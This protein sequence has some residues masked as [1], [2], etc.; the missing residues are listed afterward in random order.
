MKR[1]FFASLIFIEPFCG[2]G[3]VAQGVPLASQAPSFYSGPAS[4]TID[5][6][7]TIEEIFEYEKTSAACKKY[8]SYLDDSDEPK[9]EIPP[10]DVHREEIYCGKWL[11]LA[12]ETTG[13]LPLPVLLFDAIKRTWPE[14]V[15]ANFEKLG[16]LPNPLDARGRPLGVTRSTTRYTGLPAVNISCSACHVG[17]LP[18]G[19]FAVGAPNTKLDLS[20]FN[21]MSYY[22]LFATMSDKER[23][24]LH[25]KV[26]AFYLELERAERE[27]FKNGAAG[28][29]WS[30]VIFKYSRLLRVLHVGSKGLPDAQ[31]VVMPPE[32]D[33]LSWID[34]RP[35]VFNPGAPMLTLQ[36]EGVPNLSVPQLWGVRGYAQDFEQGQSAPVGQTTKYSSLEKF[37]ADAFIYAYQDPALNRPRNIRPLTTYLRQIATPKTLESIDPS[38]VFSGEQIYNQSCKSCHNGPSGESTELYRADEV[39][40]VT[41]LEN[42]RAGYLATTPIAKLIAGLSDALGARLEPQPVGIKSRRLAGLWARKNLMTHGS[43]HDLDDLLCLRDERSAAAIT[44]KDICTNFTSSERWALFSFLKTL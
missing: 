38:A 29:D 21:L 22:P 35:G 23:S 40:S 7:Q 25:P 1:L 30:D 5:V 27:R 2:F 34:G 4:Q 16:F 6:G 43:I 36:V 41:A 13:K 15:G 8:W 24:R 9:V 20:T 39:N 31:Y 19:R 33:L 44:H 37:A 42:P 10:A 11:F 26:L 14:R 32:R 17:Q 3:S 12:W 28:I 18:D